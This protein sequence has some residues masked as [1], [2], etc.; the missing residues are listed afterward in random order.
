[1]ARRGRPPRLLSAGWNVAPR[2]RVR[3]GTAGAGVDSWGVRR[4][5]R[6]LRPHRQL[7]PLPRPPQGDAR[8]S[9]RGSHPR[10]AADGPRGRRQ[11]RQSVLRGLAGY[12]R[13][14]A[15]LRA[16]VVARQSWIRNAARLGVAAPWLLLLVLASR[17]ETLVAYDSAAGATLILVGVAVTLVAYRGWSRSAGFPRSADGSAER[18]RAIGIVLG[19][20]SGSGC[21][22]SPRR[23]PVGRPRLVERV[24][25]YVADL[26]AEAREMLARGPRNRRPCSASSSC[27]PRTGPRGSSPRGSAA[28]RASPSASASPVLPRGSS[29]PRRATRVGGSGFVAGVGSRARRPDV[30]DLPAVV[31]LVLPGARGGARRALRD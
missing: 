3:A 1:M 31:R 13:E 14:D 17:H 16:E 19:A 22:S 29:V 21:G 30:R 24:A 5:R 15:A 2:Q 4:L 12:L 10:D 25:P 18:D 8:R 11:R 28:T 27:P 6:R 20:S 7:R 9:D 23:S 26:S